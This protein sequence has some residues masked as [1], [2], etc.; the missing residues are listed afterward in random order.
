[1][2]LV[3]MRDMLYHA[4][5]NSYAVGAFDLVSLD[6]LE[7][8]IGAA[9]RCRAPVILSVAE[10][11]FAH[12]DFELMLPAIEAAAKRAS[13]PVA[14]QLDHGNSLES[15]IKAINL[16]C[17]GVMMDASNMSLPDNI[18]ATKEVVDM[19][20]ACGI[21]VV[22]ELGYVAGIEGEGAAQH[23]G[24]TELTIPSQ[25][26]AY[27]ERTGVDFLAVSIGTVQGRM[28]GKAKLD[29]TRL[30]QLNQTVKIPLVI[31]GGT[32]LNGDQFRRLTSLGISKI[33]YFTG[34]S[35]I[36]AQT[37]RER[38]KSERTGSFT[39]MKQGVK[40]AIGEDVER[41][42]R[43]WGSAGR[44]AE[45][46]T[47]CAPWA[48]VEHLIIYNVERMSDEQAQAMMSEGRRV[49][50]KIPGVREVFAGQAVE[51][52]TR[53]KFCW[54]IRFTHKAVI[55]SYRKH[56]DHLDFADKLF[57]PFAGERISIDFQ[58]SISAAQDLP[59]HI[60][61]QA[62]FGIPS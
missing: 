20:H 61:K 33:N 53:Y 9:E 41:C 28:K 59:A 25:A 39:D 56:P 13:I 30:K 49:L 29:F 26:K 60:Q 62:G 3:N 44:A 50:A 1:M 46:L 38:I 52:G 18:N 16:G 12:Y 24:E 36:A 35:D 43:L 7:A 11:H 23:P 55:E 4:Y 57:R 37:M 51:E 6:F 58:D 40:E 14:I 22:G 48:S 32:G 54:L 10:P 34:L 8:V 47:Q 5:E 19:A 31:H 21:P 17:N 42:L 45:V 2:P 27:V 15:T